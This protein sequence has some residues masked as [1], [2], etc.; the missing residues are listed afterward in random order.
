MQ[1]IRAQLCEDDAEARSL[2]Q[3]AIETARAQG[4]RAWELRAATSLARL[5]QQSGKT[6]EAIGLLSEVYGRFTEGFDT[7]DLT[8]AHSLIEELRGALN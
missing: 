7:I 2:L 1:R 3:I 4:A 6:V 8:S 5:W